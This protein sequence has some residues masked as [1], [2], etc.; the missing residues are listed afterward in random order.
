[1]KFSIRT[2]LTFIFVLVF[3]ALLVLFTGVVYYILSS[4]LHKDL[5][6]DSLHDMSVMTTNMTKKNWRDEV[7]E[8][9]DE[10]DEFRLLIKVFDPEGRPLILAGK[11]LPEDWPTDL[12]ELKRSLTGPQWSESE[13]N[14]TPYLV[15]T[16][17][18]VPPGQK[19]HFVQIANSGV[20]GERI[21][22]QFI[23]CVNI[24][25]PIILLV[26]GFAG[27]FF[28]RR[29]LLPVAR[30]SERAQRINTD[31]L[32]E[33]LS[34]DGP[35]DELQ[36]LTDTLNGM[37]GRVQKSVEQMRGFIADASHELRI[38]ITGLRGTLEVA[39]RN[40]RSK[41]D[42][43]QVVET[44]YSESERLSELVWDLLSLARSDA[45]EMKVEKTRVDLGPFIRNVFEEANI[46]NSEKQVAVRLGNVP[47]GTGL[48][49]ETK[50]HQLLINLIENAIRYNKSGGEVVLSGEIKPGTLLFSVKDTG[51]GI[52]K[53]DLPRI[54]DR[55]YRVD[56]ARS[57]EAGGTGL[58]LSI[59]KSI[60]EAHGGSLTVASTLGNGSEFTLKLPV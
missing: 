21:R 23:N 22:N 54:F 4:N 49:D 35:N 41:E 14:E 57:R 56:K 37:L 5:V 25:T 9:P 11:F 26:A 8:M 31:N 17:S 18:F 50:V 60:A 55:F 47:Q 51:I 34:Y 16:Q 36:H 33:R 46:I 24:G 13:I 3:A 6:E 15:L 12:G 29:A 39:L 38:P 53:A 52:S 10:A 40:D 30:I 28:S 43:K 48:F 58:G 59:A 19:P 42:Y 20:D 2:R 27:F 7:N 44:A 1:M 45:G 32:H